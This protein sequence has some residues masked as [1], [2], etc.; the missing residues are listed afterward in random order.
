[1][2]RS[3][4]FSPRADG[5]GCAAPPHAPLSAHDKAARLAVLAGGTDALYRKARAALQGGDPQ[6]AAVLADHLLALDPERLDFYLL[7]SD[8]LRA[9]GDRIFS[10]ASWSGAAMRAETSLRTGGGEQDGPGGVSGAPRS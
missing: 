6:W 1:M 9:I 3:S 10:S 4:S 2:S 5:R 8:A 7:K